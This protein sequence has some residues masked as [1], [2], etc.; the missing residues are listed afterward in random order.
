MCTDTFGQIVQISSHVDMISCS[1]L[2][3]ILI[4]IQLMPSSQHR[5]KPCLQIYK[6]ARS[7]TC[8]QRLQ[9]TVRDKIDSTYLSREFGH[10]GNLK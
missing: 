2:C 10:S 8:F 7:K 4:I 5:S 6:K 3:R 1:I 9:K